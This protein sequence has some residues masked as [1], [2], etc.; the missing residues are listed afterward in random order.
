[1]RTWRPFSITS[2]E[3]TRRLQSV[4]Y[5]FSTV[6]DGGANTGQFARACA[7]V[8]PEAHIYSYEPLPLVSRALR[9]NLHDL[10]DRVQIEEVALGAKE[11][12]V[13]FHKTSYSLQSSVL[14]P[15]GIDYEEIQVRQA[16]LD[17]LLRDARLVSPVLLK[18][19]LQGYELEAL[20]GSTD[21][22]HHVNAVLLEVGFEASYEGEPSFDV[23][24]RFLEEHGFAFSRPFDV[25]W[26]HDQIVQM[27]ALFTRKRSMD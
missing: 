20:K 6:V 27:D 26:Q 3:L 17:D 8:W 21:L 10:A 23:L 7:E 13:I 24:C 18:L 2:F 5:Q 12:V 22:L 15:V 25:L 4:G 16:R 14:T 9:Q 1:M 11:E 19:D